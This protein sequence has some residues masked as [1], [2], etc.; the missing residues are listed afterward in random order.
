MVLHGLII[1]SNVDSTA[2]NRLNEVVLIISLNLLEHGARKNTWP[3]DFTDFHKNIAHIKNLQNFIP[4]HLPSVNIKN[5][6]SEILFRNIYFG[7]NITKKL[8]LDEE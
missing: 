8:R 6:F 5:I 7:K 1:P 2:A 3:L 4:Q